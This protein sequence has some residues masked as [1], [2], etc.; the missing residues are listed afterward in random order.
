LG[1]EGI[2]LLGVVVYILYHPPALTDDTMLYTRCA[3]CKQR[4][5]YR[6]GLAGET[7]RCPR[8]RRQVHFPK[9][10]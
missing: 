1:V 9:N 4:L 8:C 7:G 10:G 5:R 6:A 3:A 2:A